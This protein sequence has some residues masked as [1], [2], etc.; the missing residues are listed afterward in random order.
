MF[1][2]SLLLLAIAGLQLTK[3]RAAPCR[4]EGSRKIELDP[5]GPSLDVG[6]APPP[7]NQ[8]EM[9]ERL[10]AHVEHVGFL[11]DDSGPGANLGQ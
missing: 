9:E 11:L 2:R 10:T 1:F 3:E 7:F 8:V 6:T 5:T 4:G